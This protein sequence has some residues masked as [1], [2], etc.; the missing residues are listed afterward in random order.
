RKCLAS[1]KRVEDAGGRLAEI[2]LTLQRRWHGNRRQ[3]RGAFAASELLVRAEED[4]TIFDERAAERAAEV[5]AVELRQ[6]A[7]E[8]ERLRIEILVAIE[9]KR[10]AVEG[11]RARL[12]DHVDL[13]AG[14]AVLGGELSRLDLK[15][16]DRVDARRIVERV[17]VGIDVDAAVEEKRGVV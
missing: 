5:V 3:R 11:G 17:V 14:A 7:D 15:F 16:R 10:R 8:V 1:A 2:A 6:I 9:F 4:D 12:R 13:A